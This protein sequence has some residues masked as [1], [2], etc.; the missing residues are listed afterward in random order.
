M[1]VVGKWENFV[2]V[3]C[4]DSTIIDKIARLP[5]VRNTEKVWAASRSNIKQP[6]TQRDTLADNI[7]F[8]TELW[9]GNAYDQIHLSNG[10]KLHEAGFKG[11][12]MTIAVIDAGFHNVDIITGMKNIRISG[13]KDFVN[14]GSDIYA[15]GSHGTKVLSCI[16][17]NQPYMMV[18]TA[19]EASYWLLRS[20]DESSEH[21]VEQDYWAAAVEFADSLGADV[22]NTSLGYYSFDDKTKN[23]EYCHLNGHHALISRQASKVADKGMVMICS[24]GNT[25]EGPWKKT[26]PPGDAH[27]VLTVGAIN[28][29]AILASFSSVGNTTDN[30]IKPDVTALGYAAQV[31]D[32]DGK[33]T[34]ANGTSFSSP[35]MCGMVT[36]LW[37]ACPELT[38]KQLLELVRES[39]DRAE[40]PDNIYG[41]GVPDVWKAYVNYKLSDGK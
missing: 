21:L 38:A 39:G 13:T 2:T 24:A 15:E 32:T 18:G 5:F 17:L 6:A 8:K 22:I 36:C 11:E 25:G 16:A 41:Y 35:V 30:R 10:D 3:S 1:V 29:K 7:P 28:K 40:C 37:Q 27:N 19:P 20:E 12:G 23:Y 33:I 14:P 31:M 9:Y 34:K 26:T 4:N